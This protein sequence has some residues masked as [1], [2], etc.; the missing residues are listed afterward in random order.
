M[1]APA[2]PTGLTVLSQNGSVF[3]N[4]AAPT[5]NGGAA[6]TDYAV[7]RRLASQSDLS[8]VRIAD[9]L[10]ATPGRTVTCAN[11]T[12]YVF[13]VAA[14]NRF[15]IGAYSANSAEVT[16]YGIPATPSAPTCI[17]GNTQVI[18]NWVA[19]ANNGSAITDYAIQ[20]KLNGQ[21]DSAYQNVTDGVSTATTYTNTG[22]VNGAGYIFRVAA[23]NARGASAWSA[24]SAFVVPSTSPDAP[25][26]LVAATPYNAATNVGGLVSLSWTAPANNGA[27]ISDYIIE[28]KLDG[29]PNS[30]FVQVLDAV[31][32]AVTASIAS[33]NGTSYVFRVAAKNIKGQGSY[34]ANSNVATP[35]IKPSVCPPPICTKGFNQVTLNWSPATSNGAAITNHIVQRKISGQADTAYVSFNTGSGATS[36]TATGL[37]NGTAYVFRVAAINIRGQGPY[38]PASQ[39]VIPGALPPNA[40]TN[41]VATIVGDTGVSLNWTT[42]TDDGHASITRYTVQARINTGAYDWVTVSDDYIRGISDPI[43]GLDD[44]ETIFRVAAVNSAGTGSYTGNS[45]AV[46]PSNKLFDKSSWRDRVPEPYRTYLNKAADRWYKYIKYNSDVKTYL[47]NTFGSFYSTPWVGIR[48]E[49]GSYLV[50]DTNDQFYGQTI[51]YYH[52]YTNNTDGTIAAAAPTRSLPYVLNNDGKNRR[53][54]I[55]MLLRIN[56]RWANAPADQWITAIAHELGHGLGI[57]QYWQSRFPGSTPPTDYFLNGSVYTNAQAAYNSVASVSRTKYPIENTGGAGSIGSHWENNFRSDGTGTYPGCFD[58]LMVFSYPMGQIPSERRV[59]SLLSIKQLVD[60]GWE[61]RTPNTSEGQ[62]GIV[63]PIGLSGLSVNPKITT[64]GVVCKCEPVQPPDLEPIQTINL[65]AF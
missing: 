1:P 22:L 54:T 56:R 7:Y 29:Q 3:L 40:P 37:V 19:P 35:S 39:L 5:N 46:T 21:A 18:I 57:G 12:A 26:S 30:S 11:G 20:R 4:W 63:R 14:I 32:P 15:G 42:P 44:V 17:S 61:E 43:D 49:P 58:E 8:F 33:I 6:I 59:I 9:G 45:N 48:I 51:D 24:G 31:S 16:P 64:P 60:F 65:P 27:L 38:S 47:V 28:R 10:K 41:L 53:V 13:R 62:P 23:I 36:Y 34:S 50:T 25:T 55:S 2:A 52:E